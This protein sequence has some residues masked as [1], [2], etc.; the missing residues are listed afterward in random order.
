MT[1]F[2]GS[3]LFAQDT[4][5]FD[6]HGEK[7]KSAAQMDYYA[8]ITK[9]V[10]DTNQLRI[11]EY[12]KSGQILSDEFY[13]S[14]KERTLQGVQKTWY[15]S[16]AIRSEIGYEQ[17]KKEGFLLTYWENGRLK[18]KDFFKNGKFKK[19]TCWD[20]AGN[21][22][23]HF[24][25]FIMPEFPGGDRNFYQYLSKNV[26]YPL[27]SYKEKVGGRVIIRFTVEKDGSISNAHVFKGINEELNWEALRVVK[28]M[29][30]W[31]PGK[32]DGDFARIGYSVPISFVINH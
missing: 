17:G 27:K 1:F 15:K 29:P 12:S 26:R 6:Q 9:A 13:V 5:Y 18:R 11:K 32:I 16:G 30:K 22:I 24:D 25:Y 7:L 31:T 10:Q 21:S 8:V 19:G 4:I 20:E 3:A 2:L 14:Y 23:A 28:Y